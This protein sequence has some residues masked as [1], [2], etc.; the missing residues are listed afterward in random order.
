MLEVGCEIYTAT[1]SV[2]AGSN[3]KILLAITYATNKVEL[4]LCYV[5]ILLFH[6]LEGNGTYVPLE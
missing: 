6:A 5:Q 3:A 4:T 2:P 1:L